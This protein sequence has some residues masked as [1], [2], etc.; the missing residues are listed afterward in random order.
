[1]GKLAAL[2]RTDCL[3]LILDPTADRDEV[4]DFEYT[5]RSKLMQGTGLLICRALGQSHWGWSA[6][7]GA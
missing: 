1:M 3:D 7:R 6:N 5:I 4:Q 2:E